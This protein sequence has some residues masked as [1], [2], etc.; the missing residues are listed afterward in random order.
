MRP[1]K[2]IIIHC[3]D[4]PFG[5]ASQINVWHKQRGWNGIGYHHVILNGVIKKGDPYTP[6]LDGKVQDG[7]LLEKIGAHCAGHNEASI[8]ICLIGVKT[9]TE[10]QFERLLW[11]VRLYSKRFGIDPSNVRGHCEFDHGKTCPNFDV[12]TIR[13]TLKGDSHHV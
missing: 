6:S 3:S 5:D 1:I 13:K 11:L 2:T 7:R 9:F 4:S 10:K 12:Q 8:G